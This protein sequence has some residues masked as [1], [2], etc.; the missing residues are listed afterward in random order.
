[1]SDKIWTRLQRRWETL[2]PELPRGG[3]NEPATEKQLAAVERLIGV[4]LPEGVHE[5]YLHFNGT[6]RRTSHW[7]DKVRA[8]PV[9]AGRHQWIDLEQMVINWRAISQ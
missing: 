4:A 3:L 7:G 6:Q 9:I 1:M 8:P 2:C 5:A